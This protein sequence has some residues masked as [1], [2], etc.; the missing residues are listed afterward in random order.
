MDGQ[1]MVKISIPYFELD[2]SAVRS[3]GPGG[4]HVNR[5]SSAVLIVWDF[6]N[7]MILTD[8]QKM[9]LRHRL[10]RR[11]NKDGALQMR[12]EEQRDQSSN[13]QEAIRK[14]HAVVQLAL[15]PQKPR[16]ATKP[17][18]SSVRRRVESKAHRSEIKSWRKKPNEG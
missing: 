4:Q 2:F 8:A 9:T 11:L 13:K 6:M 12:S 1:E 3:S 10:V 14:L 17:T 18:R 5:T 15:T 16:K 7:S